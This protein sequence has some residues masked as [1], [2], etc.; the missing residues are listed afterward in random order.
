MYKHVY[1]VAK[2]K[3]GEL[4][5]PN[6][7]KDVE[8]KIITRDFSKFILHLAEFVDEFAGTKREL[9]IDDYLN[10]PI[11]IGCHNMDSLTDKHKCITEMDVYPPPNKGLPCRVAIGPIGYQKNIF[12]GSQQSDCERVAHFLAKNFM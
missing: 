5:G 1:F 2:I 11:Y 10:E 6:M 3:N 8:E 9:V 4:V 12:Y 7:R